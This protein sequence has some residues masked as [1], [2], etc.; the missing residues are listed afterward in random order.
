MLGDSYKAEISSYGLEVGWLGCPGCFLFKY[1][2]RTNSLVISVASHG[3][4]PCASHELELFDSLFLGLSLSLPLDYKLLVGRESLLPTLISLELH[5]SQQLFVHEWL[6]RVIVKTCSAHLFTYWN[7]Y[8]IQTG[9]ALSHDGPVNQETSS[10]GQGIVTLFRKPADWEDGRLMSQ[11]TILL[12][13]EF[14][15]FYKK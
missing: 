14:G 1:G 12:Q 7:C 3:L 13:S 6:N 10:W 5:S 4:S 11:R 8:R 15:L 9:S 2:V